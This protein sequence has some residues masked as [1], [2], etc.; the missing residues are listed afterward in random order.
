MVGAI[1]AVSTGA[2]TVTAYKALAAKAAAN[3]EPKNV[4]GGTV[5]AMDMSSG[6]TPSSSGTG[7]APA[8]TSPVPGAGVESRSVRW[9]LLGGSLVVASFL[10]LLI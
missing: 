9:G 8:A 5:E 3:V 1:N 4:Q 10:G 2:K 6:T 7:A